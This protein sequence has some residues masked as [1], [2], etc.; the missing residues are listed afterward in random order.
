MNLIASGIEDFG[1]WF[2]NELDSGFGL[3]RLINDY[4]NMAY[5]SF[6]MKE[7]TEEI[8]VVGYYLIEKSK[9]YG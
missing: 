8:R 2:Y 7:A 1:I 3:A 6:A 5:N 4:S 9:I